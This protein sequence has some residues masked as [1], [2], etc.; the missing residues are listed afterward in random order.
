MNTWVPAVVA[1]AIASVAAVTDIVEYR[2][3]NSLTFSMMVSGMVYHGYTAG[4]SG[5][6]F[7]AQGC[8]FGLAVLIVPW[9]LGLMGASDAKLL[10]GVGAWL[11]LKGVIFTFLAASAVTFVYALIVIIYRGKFRES[12]LMIKVISY[13]FVAMGSHFGRSDIVEECFAGPDRRLRVIPF[14]AMVP[15]GIL[16]AIWLV[17]AKI[18]F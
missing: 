16:G 15:I 10:A 3:R 6:A 12:L 13:R 7:S 2:I 18:W 5:L 17:W 9:L 1:L 8:A 4:W 14:G 11:G